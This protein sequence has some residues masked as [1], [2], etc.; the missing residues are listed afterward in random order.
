MKTADLT[1]GTVYALKGRYDNKPYLVLDTSRTY[2]RSSFYKTRELGYTTVFESKKNTHQHASGLLCVKLESPDVDTAT[3]LDEIMSYVAATGNIPARYDIHIVYAVNIEQ[4]FA[5]Y[6]AERNARRAKVRAE[7]VASALRNPVFAE[8][9]T[10]LVALGVPADLYED[11]GG[12]VSLTPGD[13]MNLIERAE[14]P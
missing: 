3:M 13:L 14:K 12:R 7:A 2:G 4:P 6:V 8:I 10:R 5:D 11:A 9:A 1:A